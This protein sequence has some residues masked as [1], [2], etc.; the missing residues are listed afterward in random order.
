MT[1]KRPVTQAVVFIIDPNWK[2]L[3]CLSTEKRVNALKNLYDRIIL[4]NKKEW[5]TNIS[6]NMDELER[7][8]I[9]SNID[10]KN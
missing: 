4:S 10:K 8:Y 6:Y 7:H 2:Q 9:N 1:I 5:S 3:R